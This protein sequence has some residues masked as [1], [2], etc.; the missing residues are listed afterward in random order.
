MIDRSLYLHR[1][2]S[3]QIKSYSSGVSAP[4]VSLPAFSDSGSK[5][6]KLGRAPATYFSGTYSI[7]GSRKNAGHSAEHFGP[8]GT[9]G[10]I[11]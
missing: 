4:S 1:P 6:L 7:L 3:S 8:A 9:V 5:K 10:Y 11:S 2:D